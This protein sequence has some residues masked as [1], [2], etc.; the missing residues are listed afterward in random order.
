LQ[1]SRRIVPLREL[2]NDLEGHRLKEAVAI[3]FDDGY[4]D[5]CHAAKPLLERLSVSATLFLMT[6]YI[7]R[8]EFWWDE[9][10]RVVLGAGDLPLETLRKDLLRRRYLSS[11][12]DVSSMISP[13]SWAPRRHIAIARIVGWTGRKLKLWHSTTG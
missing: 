1:Q 2:V 8:R 7:G 12:S 10:E 3:T 13:L 9:L 5:N 4:S 11:S 6:G